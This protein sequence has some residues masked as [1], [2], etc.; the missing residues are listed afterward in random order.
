MTTTT[1]ATGKIRMGSWQEEPYGE[2]DGAPKL[3]PD[4]VT[5]SFA[6]DIEG[7][8]EA[9]Y[10]NAYQDEAT[11]LYVGYERVVGTVGQRT[12]TFV[13]AISGMY[14]D[15]VARST[16]S[17]VPG[18]GT[19]ELK[20]LRGEGGYDAGSEEGDGYSYRLDYHFE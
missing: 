5:H 1:Q 10:L 13:L 6:G 11:A 4:R 9:Q 12:G 14:A 7:R 20:G 19:G 15:G 2:V 17:V 18:A 8:A 3:S 16:W